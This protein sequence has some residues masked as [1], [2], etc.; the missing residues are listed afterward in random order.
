ME[1]LRWVVDM[2]GWETADDIR[3][4]TVHAAQ[5]DELRIVSY[6]QSAPLLCATALFHDRIAGDADHP[7]TSLNA[8]TVL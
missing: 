7:I 1:N 3:R 8:Y 2:E 5:P 6:M 4:L